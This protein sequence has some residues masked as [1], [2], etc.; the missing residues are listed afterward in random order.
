MA[1][2]DHSQRYPQ[3]AL[4]PTKG[5]FERSRGEMETMWA[6]TGAKSGE[7]LVMVKGVPNEEQGPLGGA[8]ALGKGGTGEAEGELVSV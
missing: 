4:K 6:T 7:E 2:V 3:G 8:P 5:R 1:E